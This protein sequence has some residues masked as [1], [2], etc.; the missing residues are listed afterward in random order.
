MST[1]GP[2]GSSM[3]LD[4]ETLSGSFKVDGFTV[5][6]IGSFQPKLPSKLIVVAPIM[7]YNTLTDFAGTYA[8]TG[9]VG[10]ATVSLTLAGAG[11][12][13][14]NGGIV[15]PLPDPNPKPIVGTASWNIS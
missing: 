11:Q 10:P 15:P 4:T 5:R 3:T 13:T 8:V 9:L 14:I 2:D 7:T 12:L 1:S 6:V